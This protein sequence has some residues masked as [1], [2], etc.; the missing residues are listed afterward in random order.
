METLV[1]LENYGEIWFGPDNPDAVSV[2]KSMIYENGPIYVLMYVDENFQRWG[3]FSHKSTSYH[4]YRPVADNYLNHAVCI[5]GWK[6]DSSIRNGGYWICKNSWGTN[7]GYNGFFNIEYGSLNIEYYMAW[8]EYDS[9]S[10]DCPP[11]V[12]AG[13]IQTGSV[14]D[15]ISFDGSNCF[16]SEG[17]IISFEWDFGDGVIS[18]EES[19]I[20]QYSEPGIYSVT[21][22]VKDTSNKTSMDTTIVC[23]DEEPVNIIIEENQGLIITITNPF[24]HDILDTLISVTIDGLFQNMDHRT[25]HIDVISPHTS[26]SLNLPI[27]G[28]GI[29]NLQIQYENMEITERFFTFGPYVILM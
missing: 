10:F 24:D 2:M 29:G 1:P 12:D 9:T 23:I 8:P 5:V 27:I 20:H 15:S 21:L 7:W 18:D 25:Q 28:L 3:F 22:T 4:R 17:N 26:Y 19:P 13:C 16:D 11:N 6:D 14:D